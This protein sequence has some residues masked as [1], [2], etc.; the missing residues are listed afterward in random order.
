MGGAQLFLY[1]LTKELLS[2]GHQVFF[3]SFTES[4]EEIECVGGA[5]IQHLNPSLNPIFFLSKLFKV[6]KKNDCDIYIRMG[7]I[8]FP[9]IFIMPF[10]PIFIK[11][12]SKKYL[13]LTAHEDDCMKRDLVEKRSYLGNLLYSFHLNL[14]SGVVVQ[15]EKQR[16]L[17]YK[18]FNIKALSAIG[19]GQPIPN[20]C[21]K[22]EPPFAFWNARFVDWKRPE[23]FVRLAKELPRYNFKIGGPISYENECYSS[24][25]DEINKI[26]NLEILPFI[27]NINEFLK[28][29]YYNRASMFIETL[30]RGGFENTAIQA[31]MREV[32]IISYE[33]DFDN[34]L[35]QEGFGYNCHGSFNELKEKVKELFENPKM[36]MEMGKKGK[37]YCTDKHN[38]HHICNQYITLFQ[39]LLKI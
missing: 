15:T 28:F 36:R 37:A 22:D 14:S 26:P 31:L 20:Q 27:D 3:I 24:L 21:T 10:F 29:Q 9:G 7:C 1:F 12:I 13:F 11:I 30:T 38:I 6:M 8:P 34:L 5:T 25:K 17:L 32:P 23:L 19:T 33:H 39:E 4:D 2:N 16:K 18:Y 35:E